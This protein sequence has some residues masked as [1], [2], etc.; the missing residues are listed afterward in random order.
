[1][2]PAFP[3]TRSGFLKSRIRAPPFSPPIPSPLL[4]RPFDVGR[5][6]LRG[7]YRSGRLPSTPFPPTLG[8]LESLGF[9]Q[10]CFAC[11]SPPRP[12]LTLTTSC[13]LPPLP[14]GLFPRFVV[15]PVSYV[16]L[17][18]VFLT[19]S[20]GKK[21]FLRVLFTPFFVCYPCF[22]S[23]VLMVFRMVWSLASLV[24]PRGEKQPF[25]CPSNFSCSF[26]SLAETQWPPIKLF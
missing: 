16:A 11:V 2:V 7:F 5:Q 18:P 20:S 6:V 15:G 26:F 22:F 23:P 3:D 8:Y 14:A 12:P 4:R 19:F 10:A 25:T 1:V 9:E 17:T 24:R 21:A 13:P